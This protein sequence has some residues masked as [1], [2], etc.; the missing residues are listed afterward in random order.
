[1]IVAIALSSDGTAGQG[2]G[3]APR[4]AIARVIDGRIES[5]DEHDVRWDVLHDEG[6]EG[7][8]HARIARFLQEQGVETVVAGHMGPPMVQTLGR[9]HI[10]VRLGA[11][12]DPRAAAI[13]ATEPA[14]PSG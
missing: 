14:A 11:D 3:R 5:W 4:V 6:T 13:K 1:V 7:G 12:G 9:M 2:W 10:D 8:H